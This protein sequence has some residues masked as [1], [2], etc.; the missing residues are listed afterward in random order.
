MTPPSAPVPT[1]TTTADASPDA[2]STAS[3]A[4]VRAAA[5]R[6]APLWPLE[7]FVAVNPYLGLR[8][9]TFADAAERLAS[10]AGVRSTLPV[11]WYLAALD[12]GRLTLDDVADALVRQRGDRAPEPAAFVAALRRVAGTGRPAVGD[13]PHSGATGAIGAR[14]PAVGGRLDGDVDGLD[15]PGPDGELTHAD[16]EAWSARVPTVA[17][18]AAASTGHDWPRLT[19]DRVSAW[20]AAYFDT[21]QAMWRSADDSLPLFAAW[22]EEAEVDRTPEVM[23]LRGFRDTA[24]ALPADPVAAIEHVLDAL[25]IPVEGRE[26]YLHAVLLQL[27]GWAAY[28]ARRVWEAGLRG[29]TDDTVIQFT[30]VLLGWELA[31]HRACRD[32]GVQA[33]WA[34]ATV[35]LAELGE[36]PAVRAA[37]ADRL[38]LQEAFDRAEQRRLAAQF[39][40]RRPPTGAATAAVPGD[41]VGRPRAQAVFCIDVRSEVF[42]RH[43]E[44]AGDGVDTVGFAGFFGFPV[45][46]V[47]LAHSRAEAQCPVL[48]RAGHT[49][50]ETAGG[51]AHDAKAVRGRRLDHHVRRAWKSFKMGAIS[52]FSFVGPVGLAYLPK[53]FT[54]GWGSTRPVAR[55]DVESLD[56]F[57]VAHRGPSLDPH[58]SVAGIQFDDRVD[59]AEGALRGMSLTEGLAPLVLLAGHGSTTTN[60]PYATGLDCGACG[61]HTGEVNAR[62][63]AAVLDDAD[64]RTVLATRGVVVPADTWFV[65]A[66]HDTT[67]DTVTVFD[68]DAVPVTHR[69]ALA[70]LDADLAVAGR[71]ARTER[72]RR[73]GLGDDTLDG[74]RLDAAVAGRSRDWAQVRPEWGLAGCRTFVAAPRSRTRDLDLSGRSFLHSY[75]WRRDEGFGVLE[76]IMTAPMVVASWISLQYFASTVENDVF[77]SGNKTLHNVVGKVGILEGYSGDLRTGLP[78]QSVHD[79]HTYQHEPLRLTVVIEAPLDAIADV[80]VAHPDV[81]ELL[82]NG[83][84]QLLAMDDDGLVSHRYAGALHW[85]PFTG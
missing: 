56:R 35:A 82:D 18:V 51:A 32:G 44:A 55:P 79:G 80:L 42:R 24:R 74:D 71:A 53:L 41:A 62:I 14:V 22:R 6:I 81:R 1:T 68:R 20:A 30:A 31:I 37:V 57:A 4:S 76:L 63:A 36:R 25:A 54:D 75:D 7:A 59:M 29:E 49:V 11:A 66:Q 28:S 83:W 73:L 26:L 64:V 69:A 21:G 85:E 50:A 13:R 60:N 27:G 84:V 70:D 58:G 12:A 52:C 8:D 78:W 61:G 3:S 45:D 9:L 48:L 10:V 43:L 38:V 72:S 47:P 5:G 17:R 16:L 19:T 23:G 77:G 40:S 65:A 2:A 33:A 15:D 34:Q 67:T 46:V 39:A